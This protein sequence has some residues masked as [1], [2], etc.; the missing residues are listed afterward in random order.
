MITP[1]RHP[2]SQLPARANHLFL[3]NLGQKGAPYSDGNGYQAALR[4]VTTWPPPFSRRG[5]V[6]IVSSVTLRAVPGGMRDRLH[7]ERARACGPR[8]HKPPTPTPPH[9][10]LHIRLFLRVRDAH[11]DTTQSAPPATLQKPTPVALVGAD[12]RRT[13]GRGSRSGQVGSPSA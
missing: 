10:C 6:S 7:V 11:D 12:G 13:S 4:A 2:G 1:A 9:L 8:S 5:I 3:F